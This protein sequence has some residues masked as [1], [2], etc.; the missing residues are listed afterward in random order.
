LA[1]QGAEVAV[2]VAHGGVVIALER[3]LGI[4]A[5]GNRHP[6][7]SGWWLEVQ[8]P[9]EDVELIPLERVDLSALGAETVTGR[10]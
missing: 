1:G 7:L 2:V 10:A 8:G 4:S 9:P 3:A 6:N 5:K